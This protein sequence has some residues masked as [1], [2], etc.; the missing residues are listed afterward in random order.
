MTFV[1]KLSGICTDTTLPILRRDRVLENDNGGIKFLYDLAFPPSYAGGNPVYGSVISDIS[2]SSLDA[3]WDIVGGESVTYSWN[4]F[5]LS[6]LTKVG[7]VFEVPPSVAAS[8]YN[9]VN[10]YFLAC[11][12]IKLPTELEWNTEAAI[13]PFLQFSDY[14]YQ[15]HPDLLTLSFMTGGLISS[16][17]QTSVGTAEIINVTPQYGEFA[18]IS[19]WRDANGQGL[20]VRQATADVSST[21][22]VGSNNSADF[23]SLTCKVGIPVGFNGTY[24]ALLKAGSENA[25]QMKIYRGFIENL[26]TSGRTPSELL[27]EDWDRTNARAV[28]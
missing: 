8:I 12:Y 19:F 26:E 15:T 2:E 18:Q 23:S 3:V 1:T 7:S 22:P 17:R 27:D 16:R 10:D 9:S 13:A 4:G 25:F 11:I 24:G 5:N 20:R 6:A 14:N 28:F 21:L